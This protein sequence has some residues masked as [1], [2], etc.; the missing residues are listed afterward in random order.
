MNASLALTWFIAAL[1]AP[2]VA[3]APRPPSDG[4]I[5]TVQTRLLEQ[6]NAHR[7]SYGLDAL[8]LDAIAQ[9]AAQYQAQDM[10]RN[11]TM[12]HQDS[13]GRSP[14]S[15]Y[16]AFGGH[17]S[18]Y[19]ENV[20]FYGDE[21]TESRAAWA[22]VSKLDALMMAERPPEDGHRANIL[23]PDYKGIGIGVAIGPN[24]LY[25]AEDFVSQANDQER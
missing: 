5:P 4:A 11:G 23:S 17:A 2:L 25:V 8:T 3:T 19:G 24:G 15:R 10:E 9:R 22:A 7:R 14:M 18:L 20:A 6:I 1:V 12:R 16:A 13:S 21:V